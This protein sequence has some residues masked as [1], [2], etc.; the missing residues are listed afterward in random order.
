MKTHELVRPT[1]L[2]PI[3]YRSGPSHAPLS[4]QTIGAAFTSVAARQPDALALVARHQGIR[5]TYAELADEVERVALGLLA[6][7]IE[8]GD[9][10]GIWSQTCAEWTILQ[11]ASAR[12]GAILVNVNPA[13]RTGEFRFAA[14]HSGMR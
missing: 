14:R 7:G 5:L 9:R 10:V 11:F 6:L 12:V 13:Y 8:K 2:P 4:S 1:P 3:S